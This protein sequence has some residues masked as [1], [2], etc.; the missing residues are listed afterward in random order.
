MYLGLETVHGAVTNPY[1]N[2]VQIWGKSP[3]FEIVVIGLFC[4]NVTPHCYL[5]KNC[6]YEHMS[7]ACYLEDAPIDVVPLCSTQPEQLCMVTLCLEAEC[8]GLLTLV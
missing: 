4:E 6:C 5:S 7:E 8:F 3:Q 2:F 1:S